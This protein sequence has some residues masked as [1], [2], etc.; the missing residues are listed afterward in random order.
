[1]WGNPCKVY[2]LCQ[3]TVYIDTEFLFG[4]RGDVVVGDADVVVGAHSGDVSN[5]KPLTWQFPDS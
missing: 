4:G 3:L 2:G 1:M 5:D